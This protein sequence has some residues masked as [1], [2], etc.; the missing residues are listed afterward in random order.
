MLCYILNI[1]LEINYTHVQWNI[2]FKLYI[3]IK[4]IT[5]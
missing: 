3:Y 4:N 5:F 1:D 2:Y